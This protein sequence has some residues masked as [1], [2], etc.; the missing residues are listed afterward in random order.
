MTLLVQFFFAYDVYY[1]WVNCLTWM[2]E[3]MLC[4][5]MSNI[6]VSGTTSTLYLHSLA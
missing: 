3:V 1:M 5:V 4:Q 6:A 2:M